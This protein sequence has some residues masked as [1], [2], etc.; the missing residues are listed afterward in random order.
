MD[1]PSEVRKWP[2]DLK[3]TYYH[4]TVEG[5][6]VLLGDCIRPDKSWKFCL[7]LTN[8]DCY[9]LVGEGSKDRLRLKKGPESYFCELSSYLSAQGRNTFHLFAHSYSPLS[10]REQWILSNPVTD[11]TNCPVLTHAQL[12]Y[13]NKLQNQNKKS[14]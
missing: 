11:A 8:A 12:P 6:Y 3:K 10:N 13:P 7:E 2:C 1:F 14:K 9:V 5:Q 4:P